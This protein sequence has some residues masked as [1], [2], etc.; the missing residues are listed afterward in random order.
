MLFR[1]RAHLR[2]PSSNFFSHV[3]NQIPRGPSGSCAINRNRGAVIQGAI[4]MR[5]YVASAA[6]TV[7]ELASWEQFLE[8]TVRSDEHTSEL[9]SL[10][11][12]SYAVFSLHKKK[13]YRIT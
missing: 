7:R 11:R 10:M 3:A 9:Q 1:T 5:A 2:K 13:H 8:K 4:S 6:K 12:I